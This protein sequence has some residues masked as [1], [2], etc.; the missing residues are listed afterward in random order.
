M[1]A[2]PVRPSWRA[3][4]ALVVLALAATPAV[5]KAPSKAGKT[6]AKEARNRPPSQ[7]KAKAKAK[8]PGGAWT[9]KRSEKGGVMQ[10]LKIQA[11][12]FTEED[13][14]GYSMPA[15]YKC[16]SCRAVMFHLDQDLRK[17]QPKGTRLKE[18]GIHGH[19][20]RNVS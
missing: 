5:G 8:G 4:A 7:A 10:E 12:T 15:R 2:L 1:A 14:Y 13:Q 9:E 11:P 3:V 20:R 16:D 19:H 6:T 17:R 18:L